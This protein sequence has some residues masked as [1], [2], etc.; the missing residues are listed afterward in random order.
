MTKRYKAVFL[1]G[2][3]TIESKDLYLPVDVDFNETTIILELMDRRMD[4]QEEYGCAVSVR[5]LP[6]LVEDKTTPVPKWR[7][8]I[9]GAMR[10]VSSFFGL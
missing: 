3:A 4:L 2:D 7:D 5:I 8:R 1:A 9:L 10:R 6:V